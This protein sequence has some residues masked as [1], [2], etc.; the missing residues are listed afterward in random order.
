MAAT[1]AR[2]SRFAESQDAKG[3]PR[4]LHNRRA[5]STRIAR[6]GICLGLLAVAGPAWAFPTNL[7][8]TVIAA[9]AV[10]PWS[11]ASGAG[12][13]LFQRKAVEYTPDP[14]TGSKPSTQGFYGWAYQG[15]VLG[16]HFEIGAWACD[17]HPL[18]GNGFYPSL[19]GYGDVSGFL[20]KW[21][22]MSEG[23]SFHLIP[24][25][26]STGIGVAAVVAPVP[27]LEFFV[28]GCN[29]A[30]SEASSGVRIRPAPWLSLG[31]SATVI[32]PDRWIFPPYLC[33]GLTAGLVVPVAPAGARRRKRPGALG[34]ARGGRRKRS[35]L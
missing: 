12:G 34:T 1:R 22:L 8:S 27:W 32:E 9:R 13:G 30:G 21:D 33:A 11:L 19:G 23:S 26:M 6:L 10:R 3:K 7:F 29:G 18:S 17:D 14:I 16:R 5:A 28:S 31:L 35:A 20:I 4:T 15:F 24:Y 25:L 2:V